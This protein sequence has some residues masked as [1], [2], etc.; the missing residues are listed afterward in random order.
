MKKKSG[1]KLKEIGKK[2]GIDFGAKGEKD[3]ADYLREEGYEAL[4][5]L[6]TK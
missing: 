4:A 5:E 6:L 2:Y 1:I 3:V